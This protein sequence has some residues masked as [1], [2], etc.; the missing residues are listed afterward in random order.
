MNAE[1]KLPTE[2]EFRTAGA[3]AITIFESADSPAALAQAFGMND[4]LLLALA[5]ELWSDLQESLADIADGDE[6]TRQSIANT[7]LLGVLT[8]RELF[9]S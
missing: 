1:T 9:A 7:Y 2:D 3:Q 6:F 8:G 5:D 4:R